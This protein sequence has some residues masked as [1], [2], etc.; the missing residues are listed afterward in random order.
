MFSMFCMPAKQAQQPTKAR[1]IT[2][3]VRL[4]LGIIF[5]V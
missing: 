1:A 4:S 2:M 3:E 5:M